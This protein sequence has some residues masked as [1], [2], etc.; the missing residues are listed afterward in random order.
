MPQD[1]LR[2]LHNQMFETCYFLPAPRQLAFFF[3]AGRYFIAVPSRMTHVGPQFEQVITNDGSST[4][5]AQIVLAGPYFYASKHCTQR[6]NDLATSAQRAIAA[7]D[8]IVSYRI[9]N[10]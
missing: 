7:T 2:K 3:C 10:I 4:F 1:E 8:L 9:R 5:L 6:A